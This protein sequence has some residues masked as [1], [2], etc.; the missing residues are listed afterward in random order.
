MLFRSIN[1]YDTILNLENYDE[2]YFNVNILNSNV[3]D[4]R[5]FPSDKIIDL[6]IKMDLEDI[7][8]IY[9][10]LSNELFIYLVKVITKDNGNGYNLSLDFPSLCFR[11][12]NTLCAED[13]SKEIIEIYKKENKDHNN[14][15]SEIL[16]EKYSFKSLSKTIIKNI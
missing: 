4:K 3:F 14:Q 1:Y 7:G 12:K 15:F 16:K 9:Y 2:D 6:K 8:L 10:K 11:I 13:L 5:E